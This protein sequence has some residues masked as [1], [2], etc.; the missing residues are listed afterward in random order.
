MKA[1]LV[2]TC[3]KYHNLCFHLDK[4]SKLVANSIVQVDFDKT[5]HLCDKSIRKRRL[6]REY[7]E[8]LEREREEKV[9]REREEEER[10]I[11]EEM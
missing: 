9:K 7:L 3:D 4:S 5:K 8:E 1:L 2:V 10:R 6:E 11:A